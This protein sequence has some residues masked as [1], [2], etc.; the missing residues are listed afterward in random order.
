MPTDTMRWIE[1]PAGR[2]RSYC[3]PGSTGD[4]LSA[5]R[6]PR[7][8]R[9]ALQPRAHLGDDHRRQPEAR[10]GC[11]GVGAVAATLD[12]QGAQQQQHGHRIFQ[13]ENS[14]SCVPP[15]VHFWPAHAHNKQHIQ[16][17]TEEVKLSTP[18]CR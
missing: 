14:S 10:C 4:E 8:R 13:R 2:A 6:C 12:L 17:P 1:T 7:R 18:L 16:P 3:L 11:E 9:Y 15:N 5:P